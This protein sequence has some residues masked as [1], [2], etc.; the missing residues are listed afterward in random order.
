VEIFGGGKLRFWVEFKRMQQ[1]N[2]YRVPRRLK[3]TGNDGNGLQLDIDR[4]IADV[5][6]KPSMFV[7][8]Q[9]EETLS[10]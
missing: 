5:S 8:T 3:I 2:G 7:L 10:H 9:P 6:L 4:Y 1:I